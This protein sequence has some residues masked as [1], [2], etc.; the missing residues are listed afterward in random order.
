MKSLLAL[1][2]KF[3][4]T[5]VR[6]GDENFC[7]FHAALRC[8]RVNCILKL[9]ISE[10]LNMLQ[11]AHGE[12]DSLVIDVKRKTAIKYAIQLDTYLFH[13]CGW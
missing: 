13:V 1:W 3:C 4:C 2:G 10:I 11:T 12:R 7:Q 5:V 9:D 8:E 6:V